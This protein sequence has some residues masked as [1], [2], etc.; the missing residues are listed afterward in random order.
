MGGVPLSEGD[1]SLAGHEI[2]SGQCRFEYC[3]GENGFES[4][5]PLRLDAGMAHGGHIEQLDCIG[6]IEMVLHGD[7]SGVMQ[8]SE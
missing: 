1:V 2:V 8:A 5:T 3:S 7:R 6:V 4:G